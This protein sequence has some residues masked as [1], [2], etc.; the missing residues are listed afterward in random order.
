M[1]TLIYGV[2]E[3]SIGAGL[4]RRLRADGRAVHLVGRNAGVVGALADEIDATFTVADVLEPG[5][6]ERATRDAGDVEALCYSVGSIVL[7]RLGQVT[8]QS[9]IED[10]TLNAAC[11][12]LAVQ[13][14]VPTLRQ[15]K[16]RVLLFSTVAV[17][18]GVPSHSI[19]AMSK[20]AVEVSLGYSES[21]FWIFPDS[22][23]TSKTHENFYASFGGFC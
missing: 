9:M 10:F 7:K 23:K 11:A 20:G 3:A 15:N 6:I 17:Q 14:G 4:A 1:R 12:A 22:V 19:T 5:A 16:G 8:M 2:G 13:Q 18:H 21:H